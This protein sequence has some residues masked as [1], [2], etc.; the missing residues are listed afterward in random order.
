MR[1]DRFALGQPM[2]LAGLRRWHRIDDAHLT[3]RAQWD[4]L[5]ADRWFQG[6]A[7]RIAYGAVCDSRSQSFE[8]LAGIEV[9]GFDDLP[10]GFGRMIVP[11]ARYAV[12]LHTGPARSLRSTWEGILHGWLPGS[13]HRP[14][15]SPDFERF[16]EPYDPDDPHARVEIWFPVE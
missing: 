10:A 2:R 5:R 7:A 6:K 13:G 3:V 14:A 11:A 9:D 15:H 4:E 8:Y 12:F 16:E 1:P